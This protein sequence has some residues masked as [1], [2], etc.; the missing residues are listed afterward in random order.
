LHAKDKHGLKVTVH[1]GETG[2]VVN[3]IRAVDEC[4]SVYYEAKKDALAQTV[5]DRNELVQHM[6]P[7]FYTDSIESC[8]QI[9]KEHN[10][11]REKILCESNELRQKVDS[12][13]DGRKILAE[14]ISSDEGKKTV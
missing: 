8:I 14:F 7:K 10:E 11:Q 5:S 3:I 13:E 6:L 2:K 4:D 1:A 12:L 9:E